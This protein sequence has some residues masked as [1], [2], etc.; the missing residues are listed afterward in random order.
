MPPLVSAIA[1]I[2]PPLSTETT[3]KH[4]VEQT[5][6]VHAA[7]SP[8]F[9]VIAVR[10]RYDRVQSLRAGRVWQRIHLWATTRGLAAQP[11]NQ[12]VEIAD[13]ERTLNKEP[14]QTSLLAELT[15]DAAWQPTFMFRMGWP[16]RAAH[17]SPR[18][19]IQDVAL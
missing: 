1:R 6:D 12:P 13:R 14:L 10:D 19:S 7:T 16:I 3:Y 11:V 8:L 15:G 9:G 5:R 4:W 2:M 18:R 17:L